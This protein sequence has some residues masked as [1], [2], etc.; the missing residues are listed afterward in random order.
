MPTA[1]ELREAAKAKK[2]QQ[3]QSSTAGQ[4]KQI[5]REKKKK[6]RFIRTRMWFSTMVAAM[7]NDRGTI[8]PNIGNNIFIGNNMYTTKNSLNAVIVIR[9]MSV[10][11]PLAFMSD[12]IYTVKSKI[13][14]ISIDFSLKN[15]NHYIN[16][17][18][19][20]LKSRI[21]N[22]QMT[23]ENPMA[24]DFHKR[25]AARLLYT[26]DVV[27]SGEKIIKSVTYVTVRAQKG[28][29]LNKGIEQVETYLQKIG[30][31][32]KVIK[33]DIRSHLEYLFM[34]SDRTTKKVKDFPH[35]ILSRQTLCEM[36]P[37]TQGSND[38]D[39]TF[40]GIDRESQN[41]YMINFRASARAKGIYVAAVSGHG[42]TVLV[43]NWFLD[44]YADGYNMC[45]MDIKGTEFI[46]FTKAAG[47]IILSMTP[48]S[49]YYVNTFKLDPTEV[50]GDSRVY[51]DERFN[52]SRTMMLILCDLPEQSVSR[53]ESLIEEF[54]QSLYVQVGVMSENENTWYRSATLNP[55][56]VYDYFIRYMSDAVKDK[57]SD[58]A[59][60]MLTRLSIYMSRT[61]SNSHMFRNE[62]SFKQIMETKVLCFNFGL[63]DSGTN[64]DKA[65]FKVRALFM[66]L[67]NESFIAYKS[68]KGEWTGKVLEESGIAEDYL[69][70]MYAKD[71]MLRRAQNQVTILLGNSVSALAENSAARGILDNINILVLGT[72]HKTSRDYLINE[73][74]LDEYADKLLE[75]HNNPDY[76]NTFLLVNRMQKSATMAMLKAFIPDRVVQGRLFRVVDT[77]DS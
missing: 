14:D 48:S 23:L 45:I 12:M 51:F 19:S 76:E 49:T 28:S 50:K 40:L 53:G 6:E 44:M 47:G 62:F 64:T 34:V 25:R 13:P 46:G 3:A 37:A 61:G 30:C 75:I 73:Y 32:Y 65:M 52:L 20:D 59:D 24:P 56:V 10:D 42:K 21:R 17:N 27:K 16:I 57:Y 72:L 33:N 60:R 11:T 63:L 18:G 29:D 55:Y 77:E 7:Y 74:G 38:I 69:L 67:M 54:L 36:L 43:Q 8:P 58:V 5:T 41:P 4:L 70:K 22:W 9:E 31:T 71:F 2:A 68:S 66:D 35:I 26:V 15:R 39:G 1:K